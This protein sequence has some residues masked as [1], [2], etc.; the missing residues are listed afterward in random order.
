MIFEYSI[1]IGVRQSS[2][3]KTELL[4]LMFFLN[5]VIKGHVRIPED[6]VR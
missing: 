3:A 5:H 2:I 4:N 1:Q 6:K